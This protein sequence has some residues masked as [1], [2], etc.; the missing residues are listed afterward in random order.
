MWKNGRVN[1][2]KYI[3]LYSII[4]CTDCLRFFSNP[5]SRDEMHVKSESK[6]AQ[7]C[8]TLCDPMDCSPPGSSVHGIFQ[9]RILEG[10]DISFSS[11]SSRLRD[12]TQ[13]SCIVG[14][15]FTVWA[16]REDMH[17]SPFKPVRLWLTCSIC[18]ELLMK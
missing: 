17:A 10:V 18:S 16:T 9:A 1:M 11:R 8:P 7:S 12:W 5:S 14:R 3:C 4:V 13:V 2:D 15:H 6:V